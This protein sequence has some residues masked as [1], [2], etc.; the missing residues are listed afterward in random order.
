MKRIYITTLFSLLFI[1]L[2]AQ[3]AEVIDHDNNTIG[4]GD[5]VTYYSDNIELA[6]HILEFK[7]KNTSSA[8]IS[9]KLKQNTINLIGSSSRYFCFAGACYPS[10]I[11]IS[12]T[13]L[14]I[15]AGSTSN[16]TDFSTHYKPYAFVGGSVEK[17]PGT[18]VIE[19][20]IFDDTNPTDSLY[21]LV[22]YTVI[23]NTSIDTKTSNIIISN[24]YPNPAKDYFIIDYNL[25]NA[26][27]ATVEVMNV[28]GST[29]ISQNISVNDMQ[30]KI[31]TNN[32]DAGVYFYNIIV[33]GNRLESKKLIIR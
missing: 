21:F 2:F 29:V 18:S 8:T 24:A 15:D 1:A 19:Y 22:K 27:T 5:T 30:A 25:E 7:V 13:S 6:E 17:F 10:S 14:T 11:N 32:L 23:D 4:N 33:D 28:L 9:Y 31:S 16:P 12:S 3:T 20:T 26:S